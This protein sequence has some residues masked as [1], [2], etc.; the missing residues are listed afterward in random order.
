MDAELIT[1][2]QKQLKLYKDAVDKSLKWI[3]NSR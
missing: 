1:I 2:L 3:T